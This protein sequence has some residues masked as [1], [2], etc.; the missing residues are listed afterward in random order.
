MT[1]KVVTLKCG[2]VEGNQIGTLVFTPGDNHPGYETPLL[3]L[4]SLAK[5]LFSRWKFENWSSNY[6]TCCN[7]TYDTEYT[8][9]K[10][11]SKCGRKLSTITVEEEQITE[12]QISLF[13]DW[14]ANLV[15][16]T[17]DDIG[18]TFEDK[19]QWWPFHSA[20]VLVGKTRE[21]VV[22][23]NENAECLMAGY[24][25][26]QQDLWKCCYKDKATFADAV[27]YLSK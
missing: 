13:K 18:Y 2:Y 8:E 15:G 16:Q 7:T 17:C 25:G 10:F 9:H 27:A 23:I 4:E 1:V 19:E 24:F 5:Y 20:R 12:S 6:I 14:V 22:C 26:S 21:E 11:C 3:A